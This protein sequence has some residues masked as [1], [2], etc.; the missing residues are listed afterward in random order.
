M[1]QP[2][3]SLDS[4]E[5]LR[6]RFGG[7]LQSDYCHGPRRRQFNV[8]A[9]EET[10]QQFETFL[11]SGKAFKYGRV[12]VDILCMMLPKILNTTREEQDEVCLLLFF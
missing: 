6:W 7:S 1:K 8:E 10:C 2:D 3:L 4:H 5:I 11:D 9:S 12:K